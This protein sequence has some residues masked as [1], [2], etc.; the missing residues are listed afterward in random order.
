MASPPPPAS[1]STWNRLC[2]VSASIAFDWNSTVTRLLP[3]LFSLRRNRQTTDEHA[4]GVALLA[5]C[6]LPLP[7]LLHAPPAGQIRH[8]RAHPRAECTPLH[9]FGSAAAKWSPNHRRLLQGRA[10]PIVRSSALASDPT[11]FPLYFAFY[12]VCRSSLPAGVLAMPPNESSTGQ[13]DSA[14]GRRRPSF[15]RDAT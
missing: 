3:A 4:E 7:V 11:P 9:R 5:C 14:A 13:R 6:H 12:A 8:C 2:A 15:S 10:A 1:S